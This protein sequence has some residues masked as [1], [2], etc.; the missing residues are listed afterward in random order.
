RIAITGAAEK[1]CG[2][3]VLT[4]VVHTID[5]DGHLTR[6]TTE[7]PPTP[8]QPHAAAVTLGTVTDVDDPERLGRVRVELPAYGGLDAGWLGVALP[9]AGR[10]KGIVALPDPD[11]T[12]LVALPGGEPAA[13]VVLG[14]LFGAIE[15]YDAGVEAGKA[16]RWSMKTAAGQR[17]VVDDGGRKLRLETE[18][19]SFLEFTPELAT[20]HAATPLVV[21]APGKAL[22]IR[23]RTVDFV[24]ADAPENPETAAQ[25]AASAAKSNG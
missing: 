20:L 22:V 16:R 12:V 24:H 17:I 25:Q 11:D 15:P 8:A 18:T 21:Q 4:E 9:G 5:A 7:P 23:A 14:S 19:G 1:V 3:Y 10:G 2:V 6:F 13:G